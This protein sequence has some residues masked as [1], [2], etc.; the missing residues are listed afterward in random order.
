MIYVR[1]QLY[2]VVINLKAVERNSE[3]RDRSSAICLNDT[4]CQTA[5]S[6]KIFADNIE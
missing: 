1:I 4:M 5:T 3:L 2:D 6:G